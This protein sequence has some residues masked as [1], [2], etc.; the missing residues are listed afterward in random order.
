AAPERASATI[1]LVYTD[2]SAALKDALA[3]RLVADK[4]FELKLGA[5]TRQLSE[6]AW[7]AK[8]D[9]AGAIEHCLAALKA[10]DTIYFMG[11]VHASPARGSD[12]E[13]VRKAQQYGILSL[14]RVLKAL[15]KY[16]HTQ[17]PLALKVVANNIYASD[18]NPHTVP[19]SAGVFS[20]AKSIA[21]EYS[22]LQVAAMDVDAQDSAQCAGAIARETVS[23]HVVPVLLRGGKRYVQTVEPISI[24]A[25]E[26]TVFRKNGVYL[27]LG[28]A[29]GLGFEL[30]CFL[31]QTVQARLIWIGRRQADAAIQAKLERIVQLGGEAVYL[32]ADAADPDSMARAIAAAKA[33][34]GAINGAIHSAAA[35]H[36][37]TLSKMSE[38]DFT[39]ALQPKVEA[40]VVLAGLLQ[41]EPMDFMLFFSSV[42][43]FTAAMGQANYS[44]GCGFTDAYARY[45]N[46]K[47][48]YPVKTINWGYW[49]S[50]GIAASEE[51][52]RRM[53]A[54]GHHSIP[55]RLG[56]EAV[57]R[58]LSD[59][60]E[61]VIAAKADDALL[62]DI[63]V[64][65]I[66]EP[67]E[68]TAP[69]AVYKAAAVA[70]A[71]RH[72][73]A[74]ELY[75]RAVDY[76][77]TVF[78]RILKIKKQ[79]L[80]ASSTFERYGIDSLISLQLIQAFEKDIGSLSPTLLFENIRIKEL[81][82][83]FCD[84]H[85]QALEKM[86]G[87][88]NAAPAM[89]AAAISVQPSAAAQGLA[90]DELYERAVDYVKTVFERI[91]K[92]KKQKLDAS[93]TFERYGIDSLISLQLIQ[94]FEKDIGSLSPTL[95]FENIRI[96]EL[97]EYFCG[98]HALALEKMFGLDLPTAKVAEIVVPQKTAEPAPEFVQ[99][100]ARAMYSG[101]IAIIGLSG[102]FPMS[103]T[104]DALWDNI[105]AGKNCIGEIPRERWDSERYYDPAATRDSAQFRS[106]WGGFISDADKFDPLF[107]NIAP[108]DAERMDPQQRLFLETAW[109][110]M[111]D[112]GYTR[113]QLTAMQDKHDKGIGVYVGCMYQ[114][115]PFVVDDPQTSG[116]LSAF[117]YWYIPNRVSAFLNL[118]GPSLAVD[119]A[120]SSSLTAIHMACASIHS[121]ECV[122]A[123]AGGVN[124]NLHPSKFALLDRM[125]ILAS[126]DHNRSLGDGDGYIPGEGV[127]AVL[128][129]PLALAEQD[130]DHIYAVIKGSSINHG[131]KTSSLTAPNPK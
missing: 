42:N 29:G 108:V 127:G 118:R 101:D 117:S 52:N 48:K 103:D 34:F 23:K 17:T 58:I 5:A 114:Q 49:G 65:G 55:P 124:L 64:Q 105:R 14:F 102:K 125:G 86:F 90:A 71:S 18:A 24:P 31:A 32:A 131:G 63:G 4:L 1:L 94:A 107:F 96:K 109:K 128:L 7:E 83:Y 95:L 98:N 126:T 20:L 72:V 44:A 130:G 40:S 36:D 70:S 39:A 43:S 88:A 115:Y 54:L 99:E 45:L 129:K 80:D 37:R 51:D 69:P 93:S 11:S 13:H 27:I 60:R 97:A 123:F 111:E 2:D 87:L 74:D 91:L 33:R 53:R 104:P 12:F 19:W 67:P 59:T 85:A 120:C 113:E 10:V 79:K 66:T 57:R 21:G 3:S 82:E 122:M 47:S 100:P 30:S 6:Q 106:K 46:G 110:T 68:E 22:Q 8:A 121:G 81:A 56:M 76:V 9:D 116:D 50:V 41:D 77:K 84:N 28:G 16:G 89:D 35:L 112:A 61:Q 73:A 78:E 62:A 75:E 15:E 38:Q 119:S 25:A 26:K 92:I